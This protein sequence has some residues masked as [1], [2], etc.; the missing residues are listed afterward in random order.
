VKYSAFAAILVAGTVLAIPLSASAQT[1]Q[2]GTFSTDSVLTLAGTPSNEVYAVAFGANGLSGGAT[3][4]TGNGY[5]FSADPGNGGPANVSYGNAQAGG[6]SGTGTPLAAGD[7]NFATALNGFD[8]PG[9]GA[10]VLKGLTVGLTY[11][12]LLL[13]DDNRSGITGNRSFSATDGSVTSASS[14][15]EFDSE[16]GSGNPN[17]GG[18]ILET[19]TAA[20]TSEDLTI[21]QPNGNQLNALVLENAPVAIPEPSSFALLLGEAVFL[22]LFATRGMGVGYARIGNARP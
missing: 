21:N 9:N 8:V 14:Q 7:A 18:Y 3:V 2:T 4:T 1:F 12:L 6:A 5:V 22:V 10:L 15:F 16:A 11:N 13:D 19:F 17:F 20:S